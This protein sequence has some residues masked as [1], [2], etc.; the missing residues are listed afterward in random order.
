MYMINSPNWAD[1]PFSLW[2]SIGWYVKHVYGSLSV[3]VR[4][5]HVYERITLLIGHIRRCPSPIVNLLQNNCS[6]V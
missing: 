6:D 2:K 4:V 3:A 5:L 1:Y